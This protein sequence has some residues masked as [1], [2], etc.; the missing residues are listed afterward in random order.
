MWI[1]FTV[2]LPT[3]MPKVDWFNSNLADEDLTEYNVL[4]TEENE[5]KYS[6]DGAR[7]FM[8]SNGGGRGS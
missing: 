5:I 6:W 2:I 3:T 7:K 4:K 8:V 1:I